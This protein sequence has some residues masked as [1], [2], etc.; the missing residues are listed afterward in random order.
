MK[1]KA[2]LHYSKH[3]FSNTTYHAVINLPAEGG[4]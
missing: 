1:C 4:N 3:V 2:F